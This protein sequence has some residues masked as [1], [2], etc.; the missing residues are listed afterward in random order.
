MYPLFYGGY[1]LLGG[2]AQI[3]TAIGVMD[4]IRRREESH[5]EAR[6]LASLSSYWDG[7]G[8]AWPAAYRSGEEHMLS[9]CQAL[10]QETIDMVNADQDM[11]LAFNQ[12][13]GTWPEYALTPQQIM[14]NFGVPV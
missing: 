10:A 2:T 12:I 13:V 9:V 6:R 8:Q 5:V 14:P 7:F 4:A 1:L 3:L 11:Q